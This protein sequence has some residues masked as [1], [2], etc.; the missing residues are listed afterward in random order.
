MSLYLRNILIIYLGILVGKIIRNVSGYVFIVNGMVSIKSMV[1]NKQQIEDGGYFP[2]T[3]DILHIATAKDGAQT[4]EIF[5][6]GTIIGSIGLVTSQK[7]VSDV[8]CET[9]L[10]VLQMR[11]IDLEPFIDY[12]ALWLELAYEAALALTKD[13][14]YFQVRF[15]RYNLQ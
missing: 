5:G 4:S 10:E 13:H 8:I 7:R 2:N 6:E 3:E 9:E 15:V 12:Q 11:I 1:H 14:A